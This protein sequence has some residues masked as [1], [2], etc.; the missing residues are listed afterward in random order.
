MR[1]PFVVV[2]PILLWAALPADA[3]IFGGKKPKGNEAERVQELIG[4]LKDNPSASKRAEAAEELR[5][6]DSAEFPEVVATLVNALRDDSSSS[7]RA[8]AA[9]SLGKLKP[10][11]QEAAQALDQAVEQDKSFMVRFKARTA[12]LGYR[13]PAPGKAPPGGVQV[14]VPPP[15]E[16]GRLRPVPIPPK[17]GEAATRPLPAPEPEGHRTMKPNDNP[18]AKTGPLPGEAE[19]LPRLGLPKKGTAAGNV[20]VEFLEGPRRD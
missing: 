13:V 19:P 16:N 3:G 7:V 18:P 1:W 11:S 4:I 6:F 8:K 15:D 2:L 14:K 5:A 17:P 12:R 10:T 20:D 9:E